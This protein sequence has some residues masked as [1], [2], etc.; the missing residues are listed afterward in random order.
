MIVTGEVPKKF[1]RVGKR[2]STQDH[3]GREREREIERERER[4]RER[5]NENIFLV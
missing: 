4:E 3:C 1:P 5:E 2:N